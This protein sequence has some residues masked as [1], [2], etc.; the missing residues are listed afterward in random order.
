[1]QEVI[2]RRLDDHDACGDASSASGGKL[3][4]R[5]SFSD[6]RVVAL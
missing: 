6:L 1:M 5:K 4:A 3:T 2:E